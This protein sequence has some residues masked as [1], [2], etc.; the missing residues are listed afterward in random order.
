M[1]VSALNYLTNELINSHI[2]SSAKRLFSF[3]V[4]FFLGDFEF[5]LLEDGVVV[6]LFFA[7]DRELICSWK[8]IVV[9]SLKGSSHTKRR[10][11]F[12]V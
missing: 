5:L 7:G 12:G 6:V 11:C 1:L 3:L 2:L 8:L 10:K 9:R 4:N